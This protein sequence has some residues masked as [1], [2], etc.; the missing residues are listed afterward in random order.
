MKKFHV[1]GD[2]DSGKGK[3]IIINYEKGKAT[4]D[5]E[6]EVHLECM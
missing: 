4:L 6:A 2:F 3:M 1:F 5:F